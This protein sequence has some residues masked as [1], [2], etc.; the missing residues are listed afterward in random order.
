MFFQD[1]DFYGWSIKMHAWR[2]VK[3]EL[4]GRIKSKI[5]LNIVA[6]R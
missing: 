5:W 2:I 1:E 4:T 6:V 3:R